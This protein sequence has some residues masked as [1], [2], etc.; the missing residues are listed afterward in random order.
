MGNSIKPHLQNAEKT[1]VCQLKNCNLNE[2]FHNRWCADASVRRLW[3][4]TLREV[5]RQHGGCPGSLPPQ[6]ND[7]TKLESLS[8]S[9]NLLTSLPPDL[10]RLT[11]L[12]SVNL[13]FNNLTAFPSALLGLRRL[14]L[15]D[16]SHN[17]ISTL[18]DNFHLLSVTEVNLSQNQHRVTY[19][20][21]QLSS[22]SPHMAD[23]PQLKVLRV[24]ENCLPL[25]AI[26][27]DLL[28]HSNISLLAADGNLFDA[29]QLRDLP[30]YDKAIPNMEAFAADS[31]MSTDM[32]SLKR[33]PVVVVAYSSSC[34]NNLH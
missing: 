15:L 34:L 20:V 30:G 14:D 25:E 8:L 18:P 33:N 6:L 19:G 2:N 9:H 11:N 13:S 22:L 24:E 27:P 26:T 28:A 12:R 4:L 32:V 29:K 3:N 23:I 10:S 31:Y 5:V 16:L 7:L 17:R 1:G 21:L